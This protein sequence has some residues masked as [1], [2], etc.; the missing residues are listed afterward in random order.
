[1][2]VRLLILGLVVAAAIGAAAAQGAATIAIFTIAGGDVGGFKGDG[3]PATSASLNG[4]A[5]VLA[6]GDGGI[7]I[8]DTI[9]QRVRRIDPSGRILTI[10]GNG[11]RGFAGDGGPPT[12]ATLQDPTALALGKDGSLYVADTGNNRIR[13]I[14]PNGVIGTVAGTSDQGF[15]GDGGPASAAQL[16]APQGLAIALNGGVFLSD[17]GNN[18]VRL[19]RPDGTIATVAGSGKA[20]FAGDGAPATGAELNAPSGL[21]VAGDGALLI[22]DTGNNRVRRVGGDGKITTVAGD[23]GGGSAGDGGDATSAQLNSPVDVATVPAGGFFVAEAGGNRIRHVDPAGHIARLAG[24][25]GPRFGGDGR[26]ASTALLNAPR[27]VELMPSGVEVLVADTD[28]DRVRYIAIP[29][30]ASRLALAPL[31]DTVTAPLV[32]KAVTVK[33]RKRRILVVKDVPITFRVTKDSRLMVQITPKKGKGASRLITRIAAGA[34]AIHLPPMS[35]SGT[36]RL[37]KGH[38]VVRMTV[39]AGLESASKTLELIVK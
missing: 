38:Y 31:K 15:S 6:A 27:A 37:K 25:G 35:R 22:A 24:T 32:K 9:N 28:N 1:M 13:V 34:G 2:R 10:A 36:R 7:L 33:K 20:G 21:A 8:A 18:R 17:T 4:P 39:T 5:G 3:R 11:S 19:I 26:A 30:Q 29:G 23:G 12:G 14:R 16:N